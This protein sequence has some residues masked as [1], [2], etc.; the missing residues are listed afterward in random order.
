[1]DDGYFFES[2]LR[3]AHLYTGH[4][5]QGAVGKSWQVRQVL[6]RRKDGI[7]VA[8]FCRYSVPENLR[9]ATN[10]VVLTTTEITRGELLQGELHV[11]RLWLEK[12]VADYPPT[13]PDHT[14]F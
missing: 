2:T 7:F 6:R 11:A 9:R 1:M 5:W 12:M 8:F 4:L 13:V 14:V 10:E 3:D